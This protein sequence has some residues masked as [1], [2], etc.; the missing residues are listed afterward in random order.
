MTNIKKEQDSIDIPSSS[1]VIYDYGSIPA[2]YY[3][4]IFNRKKGIQSAWHQ[5]KFRFLAK[6]I[7]SNSNHLDIGC[8]PGTFLGNFS[9]AKSCIGV[10]IAKEQIEF[11]TQKYANNRISFQ[12][13]ETDLLP[14]GDNCFDVV[15]LV[16]VIEHLDQV[17]LEKVMLEA[18][19][20]LKPS[21]LL[22]LSTPNYKSLWPVLEWMINKIAKISYD[23]QHITKFIPKSLDLFVTQFGFSVVKS[24]SYL[25]A[26]PFLAPIGL[27]VS[28]AVFRFEERVLRNPFLLLL[29]VVAR[30]E[31]NKS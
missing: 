21:G 16:E 20:V 23:E 24:G 10:D 26:S 27:G 30:K 12:H 15:S 9:Q 3:D 14:F 31:G 13:I 8:G 5:Q 18:N 6:L 22:I 25:F 29:Y 7:P 19:R 1:R 28:D 17:T 4:E 2:G 11:A